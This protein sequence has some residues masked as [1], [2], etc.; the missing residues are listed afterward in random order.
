MFRMDMLGTVTIILTSMAAIAFK[1][2]VTAAAAGKFEL[3]TSPTM[4]SFC[5]Y[6]ICSFLFINHICFIYS[7]L[8]LANV[9]QTATFV[10]FVALLKNEFRARFNSIERIC[11]YAK[12]RF[13]FN[14]NNH[15]IKFQYHWSQCPVI[16]D[17]IFSVAN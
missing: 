14:Y 2:K 1:G 15:F 5:K 13:T 7:G 3:N 16:Y 17:L 6:L 11:E 12:V 10:P 8:A 4:F 9:F